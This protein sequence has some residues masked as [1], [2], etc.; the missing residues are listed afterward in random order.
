LPT[1]CRH[2]PWQRSLWHWGM[3]SNNTCN[4]L[5]H[6]VI[7]SYLKKIV[8]TLGLGLGPKKLKYNNHKTYNWFKETWCGI[9]GVCGRFLDCS[10]KAFAQ[11]SHRRYSLPKIVDFITGVCIFKEW[12]NTLQHPMNF[13]NKN[14][15]SRMED[16]FD[17]WVLPFGVVN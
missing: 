3:K 12:N 14:Q 6:A 8:G 9:D 5:T 1:H 10:Y 4:S 2:R 13:N 16:E 15:K 17:D 11:L 7:S